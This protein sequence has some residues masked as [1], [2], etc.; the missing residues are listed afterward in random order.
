[1]PGA[2]HVI[3]EYKDLLARTETLIR[4]FHPSLSAGTVITTVR[5]CRNELMR[6]GV[7]RGL[8]IATEAMARARLQSR[9]SRAKERSTDGCPATPAEDLGGTLLEIG[10]VN[11]LRLTGDG[12]TP[13]NGARPRLSL[14]SGACPPH[15]RRP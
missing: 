10:N 11:G 5:S 8:A 1:M 6:T 3:T 14:V 12:R 9:T 4:E 2:A 13:D 15:L 7:R